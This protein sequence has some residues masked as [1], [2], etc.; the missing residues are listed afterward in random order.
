M[1][2]EQGAS[3][4]RMT[5]VRG[6]YAANVGTGEQEGGVPDKSVIVMSDWDGD[7]DSDDDEESMGGGNAAEASDQG[8]DADN[9]QA[10]GSSSR[11]QHK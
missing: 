6:E 8:D 9:D 4:A 11:A 1:S 2:V 5:E 10:A 3:V 7:G